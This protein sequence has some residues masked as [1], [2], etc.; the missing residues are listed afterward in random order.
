MSIEAINEQ[1]LRSVGVGVALFSG[2]SLRLEFKNDVFSSWFE[3]AQ[4]DVTLSD[5]FPD[6]DDKAMRDAVASDNRYSTEYKF[7]KGRRT[8][9]VAQTFTY[10]EVGDQTLYIL[11][12][13]NITRIREL[14]SMIDS[15]STMVERNTRQIQREK[16]QVE[17]LLL[18][19][20][21]RAAYEEYKEFGAVTP[22]RYDSVSVLVLD[23]VDFSGAVETMPP[24]TLISELGELYTAFDRIGD[25]LSCERIRTTGDS[26]RCMAGMQDPDTDHFL[27]LANAACRFLRYLQRRNENA[28]LSWSCRIGI[29][30]GTV[31]GSVV[32]NQRYVY[33]VFGQAVEAALAAQSH[34]SDMEAITQESNTVHLGEHL[35]ATE[36][37]SDSARSANLIAIMDA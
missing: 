9:I 12:C 37:Q 13:Q 33:D 21:P 30:T 35:K 24:A 22:Q 25:Q 11:E 14:E 2:Q 27:S 7:K 8:L 16:E 28:S 4:Q 32:G 29:G 1:L 5:L 36:P 20:M 3:D 19:I 26:Y 17:K 15:Y 23:F 6:I 31:V 18:N 10:A 34:A